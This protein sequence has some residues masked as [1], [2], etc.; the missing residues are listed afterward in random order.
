MQAGFA[1]VGGRWTAEA[2]GALSRV[3]G[4][5]G[6]QDWVVGKGRWGAGGLALQDDPGTLVSPRSGRGMALV[7][8]LALSGFPGWIARWVLRM[9]F[10]ALTGRCRMA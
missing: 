10:G 4:G 6:G 8:G 1:Q 5:L 9:K 2:D 3:V 7:W